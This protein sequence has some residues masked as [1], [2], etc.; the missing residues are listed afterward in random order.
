MTAVL[1]TAILFS[2]RKTG[3]QTLPEITDTPFELN[4]SANNEMSA[5][6]SGDTMNWNSTVRA[7]ANE[8]FAEATEIQFIDEKELNRLRIGLAFL[9]W[10][11][12][13]EE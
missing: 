1:L 6:P 11:V 10:A 2:A 12:R 9:E 4:E 7:R 8:T 13:A 3:L 5:S